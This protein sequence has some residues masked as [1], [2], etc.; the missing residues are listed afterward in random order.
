GVPKNACVHVPMTHLQY[1]DHACMELL[2]E[3]QR[4]NQA[5]GARLI[6]EP[7]A[8]TRRVEGRRRQAVHLAAAADG[9]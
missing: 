4:A 5:S 1:I 8:L 6:I 3:W 2:E 9:N 7:R